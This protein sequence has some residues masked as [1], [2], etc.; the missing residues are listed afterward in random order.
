MQ[1]KVSTP[2]KIAYRDF[3]T[4]GVISINDIKVTIQTEFF[5]GD[6]DEDENDKQSLSEIEYMYS[7]GDGLTAFNNWKTADS[8]LI[9]Y[10]HE[11]HRDLLTRFTNFNFDDADIYNWASNL[12][13]NSLRN[14]WTIRWWALE[15]VELEKTLEE[16][17]NEFGFIFKFRPDGSPSYWAV[18][19]SYASSDVVSTLTDSDIDDIQISHT[20]FSD[21]ITKMDIKYKMHPATED[22][23]LQQNSEDLTTSPTPRQKWNIKDKENIESI[24][25]KYNYE[26]QGNTDVG[27]S[28]SDPNDGYADYYMNIFGDIKKTVT[29]SIVNK[30]KGFKLETGDIIKFNITSVNPF[31]G[32]WN[33]YYMITNLQRSLG[34]INITCREVG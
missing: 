13:I 10:G 18:K 32:N 15:P 4:A 30:S 5:A 25:L 23:L 1:S 12:N 19:D 11:A 31:G 6:A 28:G 3:D 7:G 8:G 9:K 17:Q 22:L 26:K 29:C 33:D 21:L 16:I 27:A 2:Y 34:K 14:N 20:S 24:D